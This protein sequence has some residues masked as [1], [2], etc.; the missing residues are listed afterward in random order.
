MGYHTLISISHDAFGR[1]DNLWL[2][3]LGLYVRSC[4]DVTAAR[5]EHTSQGA[6]RIIATRHHTEP[7]YVS[8]VVD[9]FPTQLPFEEQYYRTLRWL[10]A[11]VA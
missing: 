5:I 10:E 7:F 1:S 2:G 3:H 4:D 8:K 6:V 11:V 9:G